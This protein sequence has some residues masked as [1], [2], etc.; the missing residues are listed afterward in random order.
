MDDD[1]IALLLVVLLAV[2]AA[3][4]FLL[5]RRGV[6]TMTGPTTDP[7]VGGQVIDLSQVR[8]SDL[9]ALQ[10]SVTGTPDAI[11]LYE[12]L[13]GKP[14]VDTAPT[15]TSAVWHPPQVVRR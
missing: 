12:A 3:A 6:A 15:A 4:W 2:G 13:S 5:R 1:Q 11:K 10:A 9:V 8:G 7:K 14:Y